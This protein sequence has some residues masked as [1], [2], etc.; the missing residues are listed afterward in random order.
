MIG[1][2]AVFCLPALLR[3]ESPINVGHC[4][5]CRATYIVRSEWS[6]TRLSYNSGA[7]RL[8]L[9]IRK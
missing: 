3:W 9:K 2:L 5:G 4:L 8:S 7:V 6:R 1:A